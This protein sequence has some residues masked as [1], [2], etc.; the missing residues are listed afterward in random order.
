MVM[1]A[2]VALCVGGIVMIVMGATR[3]LDEFAVACG[4]DDG[5]LWQ[6]DNPI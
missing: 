3:N 2:P 4:E 5:G 1:L 6:P